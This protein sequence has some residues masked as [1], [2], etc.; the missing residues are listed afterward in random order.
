M[1][2][3]DSSVFNYTIFGDNRNMYTVYTNLF[4]IIYSLNKHRPMIFFLSLVQ[5]K[6]IYQTLQFYAFLY[7][8]I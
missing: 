5:K 2:G 1:F 8:K 6:I 3:N 7:L 4:S